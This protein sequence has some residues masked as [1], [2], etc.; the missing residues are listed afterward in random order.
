MVAL[1]RARAMAL[2]V[3]PP[4]FGEAIASPGSF[5]QLHL[6]TNNAN[7]DAAENVRLYLWQVVG[8]FL[9]EHRPGF[10]YSVEQVYVEERG[11]PWMRAIGVGLIAFSVMLGAL[12]S[13]FSSVLRGHE[14][15]T[16]PELLMAP[17]P[18]GV[19]L[20]GKL[21]FAVAGALLSGA[22]MTA[23]VAVTC[24]VRPAAGWGGPPPRLLFCSRS[25][26]QAPGYCSAW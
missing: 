18:L 1:T 6:S 26:T 5:P 8:R 9:R 23:V 20:G 13:G 7:T 3:I 11:V 14:R 12:F 22:V 21:A 17:H 2:L 24:G 10:S 25:L 4:G 19:W 15:N 16:L